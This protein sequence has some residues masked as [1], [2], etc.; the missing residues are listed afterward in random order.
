MG[1]YAHDVFRQVLSQVREVEAAAARAQEEGFPT[2]APILRRAGLVLA[3]AAIDSYFHEQ[4]VLHLV[5]VGKQNSQDA[6]RVANY[7]QSVSAATVSGPS[8][9]SYV[10][11]RLSY[12][13]LVAPNS[14]SAMLSAAGFD[15]GDIWH[16]VCSSLGSRPERVQLQLQFTYDRRNQIAHE[17]DWDFVQLDFREMHQ[18]HLSDCVAFVVSLA[19]SVDASLESR[20]AA[21]VLPCP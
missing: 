12:K 9:E 19:E 3:I 11:L 18:V 6:A 8:A 13:T 14:I 16:D 2:A 20:A 7:L 4:A 17:G 1:S 10:R 15:P 21:G 5:N